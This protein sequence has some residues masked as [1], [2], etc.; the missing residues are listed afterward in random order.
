MQRFGVAL[1]REGE[2]KLKKPQYKKDMRPIDENCNCSTCTT[3]TRSYLHHIVR[4][5]EVAS[6]LLTVHNVA[7]QVIFTVK[8]PIDQIINVFIFSLN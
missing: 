3:Y 2:L 5:E 8:L 1:V 4:M 7:F 6:S